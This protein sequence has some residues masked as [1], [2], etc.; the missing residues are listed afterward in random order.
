MKFIAALDQSG[1]STPATLERYGI[2]EWM[3]DDGMMRRVHD[4]RLRI[5]NS[6]SFT[7]KHISTAI[8]F[9]DTISRGAVDVLNK[10][11]IESY[12]KVDSGCEEDGTLKVFNLD[13]MIQFAI[14]T[15][16]TGT[17][18]RSIIKTA[19]IMSVVL[20]QQFEYA[21]RIADAGLMPIV[22]PEIPIN[23]PYKEKLELLLFQELK[24]YLKAFAGEV[25]LKL[26]IPD[27]PNTY[28]ALADTYMVKQLV[29][30]SGGYSTE[31]ACEKL[32][33]NANMGASFSRGLTEGLH[34]H[35]TEE[36]FDEKL[37]Q[38]ILMISNASASGLTT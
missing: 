30:L 1:G 27:V 31:V 29:G 32:S 17:K 22:E 25:I 18:M 12:L 19:E 33:Q 2:D 4:M 28:V 20:E 8:M 34:V 23:H 10:K 6:P 14:D 15:G 38:N 36:Q 37:L 35:Q 11:H 21:Q 13:K 3:G 9:K 7:N 5:I 26:T 24:P 16:C